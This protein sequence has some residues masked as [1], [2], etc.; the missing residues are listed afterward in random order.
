MYIE[1]LFQPFKKLRI[2]KVR[3]QTNLTRFYSTM[4]FIMYKS[5]ILIE[6]KL[7]VLHLNGGSISG[8]V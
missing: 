8:I 6:V 5:Q 1:V 2:M 3:H 7:K 4:F